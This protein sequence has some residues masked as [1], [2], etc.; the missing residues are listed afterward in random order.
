MSARRIGYAVLAAGLTGFLAAGGTSPAWAYWTAADSSQSARAAADTLPAGQ[1]P[2]ATMSF[3]GGVATATITFDRL[4]T[5]SGQ[6]VSAFVIS[7]YNSA[8]GGTPVGTFTCTPGGPSSSVTCTDSNVP[9]GTWYYTDTPT[10]AG[11]QWLGAES[12]RSTGVA[13]DNTPPTVT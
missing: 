8:T 10:V 12:A 6:T 13:T 1:T 2:T 5:Q 3:P 4:P 9:A 11:S 7:R